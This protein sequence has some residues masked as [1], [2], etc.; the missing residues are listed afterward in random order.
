M[1]SWFT[2]S[3]EDAPCMLL[4]FCYVA[5]PSCCQL[6]RAV[7]YKNMTVVQELRRQFEQLAGG[8]VD[9]KFISDDVGNWACKMIW[10]RPF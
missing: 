4:V 1:T 10:A 5:W 9:D 8:K 6:M 2:S 3:A 7:V